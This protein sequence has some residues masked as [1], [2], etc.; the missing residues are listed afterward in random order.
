[1]LQGFLLDAFF[2]I[3]VTGGAQEC[4]SHAQSEGCSFVKAKNFHNKKVKV[5]KWNKLSHWLNVEARYNIPIKV[6]EKVYNFDRLHFSLMKAH[7]ILYDRHFRTNL[8]VVLILFWNLVLFVIIWA[9][10]KLPTEGI[11]V[12]AEGEMMFR[13]IAK[14][15]VIYSVAKEKNKKKSHVLHGSPSYTGIVYY[16]FSLIRAALPWRPRR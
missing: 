12:V 9:Y 5:G 13:V 15:G 4:R 2:L 14:K 11:A 3:I 10:R 16:N 6:Q 8:L 7:N 1:M